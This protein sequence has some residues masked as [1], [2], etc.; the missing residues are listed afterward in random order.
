MAKS[1][2][3]RVQKKLDELA[4]I[5][6]GDPGSPESLEA[7]GKALESKNNLVAGLAAQI[8]ANHELRQ[9]APAIE[10]AFA[11][12]METPVKRDPQCRAKLAMVE[13]L[14]RLDHDAEAVFR[15]GLRHV[16]REPVWGGTVDTAA[17]LRALSAIALV[18]GRYPDVWVPLGEMLAD[19]ERSAR[20]GA[21][22]A[23]ARSGNAEIGCP[24]LRLRLCSGEAD[25]EVFS[26]CLRHLMA[27][28][29]EGS[30]QFV[31]IRLGS[32]SD[33]M[34]EAAAL[35]LGESRQP[36]AFEPLR[37]FCS[38]AVRAPHRRIGMMAM[39]MLRSERAWGYLLERIVEGPLSEAREAVDA[40]SVYRHDDKLRAS[41]MQAVEDREDSRLTPFA[42]KAFS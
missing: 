24:L 7:L 30:L 2:V 3:D 38:Y 14:H 13:A 32:D 31:V 34:C 21:A 39:A 28:D 18:D 6:D 5:R 9:L 15:A 11:T 42:R 10:R 26:A 27:L 22:E 4:A 20:L 8:S 23:I 19:P 33:W 40:L 1:K 17:P 35:A 36:S 12:F 25:P 37:A 29:P 16:Q 41:V